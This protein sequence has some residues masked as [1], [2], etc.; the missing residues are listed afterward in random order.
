M[1]PR[2]RFRGI[3]SA[4]Y[5]PWRASTT[6]RVVVEASQAGN[7]F[8]SSLKGLQIRALYARMGEACCV[9]VCVCGCVFVC[10]VCMCEVGGWE[11]RGAEEFLIEG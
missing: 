8:L 9:C 2:N 6:N 11:G 5:V 4:A 10:V 1:E 3:D 7:R